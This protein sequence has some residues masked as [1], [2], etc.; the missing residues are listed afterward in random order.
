[1]SNKQIGEMMAIILAIVVSSIVIT[2][3]YCSKASQ[4]VYAQTTV[5][6]DIFTAVEDEAVNIP[7]ETQKK[8]EAVKQMADTLAVKLVKCNLKN[9]LEASTG[10]NQLYLNFL[11][12]DKTIKMTVKTFKKLGTKD[13]ERF[14]YQCE[15]VDDKSG[16]KSGD[17]LT[18][19]AIFIVRK[20]YLT[21]NLNAGNNVYS[22]HYLGNEIHVIIQRDV[23]KVPPCATK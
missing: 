7:L 10:A 1:M 21:G 17:K 9:L 19:T 8:L 15:M 14:L 22:V 20:N 5:T 3:L 16:E 23:T 13:Q 4:N 11:L 12:P 2:A 18:G 6:I